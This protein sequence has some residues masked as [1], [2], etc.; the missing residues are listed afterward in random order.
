MQ[1]VFDIVSRY[2]KKLG[3]L[4]GEAYSL[5]VVIK[6]LIPWFIHEEEDEDL[7]ERVFDYILS[8]PPAIIFYMSAAIIM[9]CKS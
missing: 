6:W 1:I 5:S 3:E 4:I 8:N 9:N 7:C 2:D